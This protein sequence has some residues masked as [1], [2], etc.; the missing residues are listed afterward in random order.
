MAKYH[1]LNYH[2]T[3]T[4]LQ[5][6]EDQTLENALIDLKQTACFALIFYKTVAINYWRIIKKEYI[7]SKKSTFQIKNMPKKL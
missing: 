1:H 4:V 5:K 3:L 6:F 7:K 2:A